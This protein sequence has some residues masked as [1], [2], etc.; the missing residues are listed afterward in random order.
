LG[1]NITVNNCQSTHT[2]IHVDLGDAA[3]VHQTYTKTTTWIQAL[4]SPFFAGSS[5]DKYTI[6]HSQCYLTFITI[7]RLLLEI[8]YSFVPIQFTPCQPFF[9]IIVVNSVYCFIQ[10]SLNSSI[11]YRLS[12]ILIE[13]ICN[14]PEWTFS[15]RFYNPIQFSGVSWCQQRWST[16]SL[17]VFHSFTLFKTF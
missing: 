17:L 4:W 14:F 9:D 6:V 11:W 1:I 16:R 13:N 5:P 3:P 12:P 10:F 15:V 2:F 8:I 7:N